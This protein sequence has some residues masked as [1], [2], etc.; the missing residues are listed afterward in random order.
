MA[1]WDHMSYQQFAEMPQE[2]QEY[3]IA[4]YRTHQ[5]VEA[6]LAQDQAQQAKA[7]A[8]QRKFGVGRRR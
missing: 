4:A 5:H 8:A 3:S 6:V 1:H 7:A 2:Y